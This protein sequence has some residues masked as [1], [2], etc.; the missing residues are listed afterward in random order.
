MDLKKLFKSKIVLIIISVSLIFIYYFLFPKK[1]IINIFGILFVLFIIYSIIFYGLTYVL[2]RLNNDIKIKVLKFLFVLSVVFILGI[3]IFK[4]VFC[5][6]AFFYNLILIWFIGSFIKKKKDISPVDLKEKVKNDLR[7]DYVTEHRTNLPKWLG[8]FV[9]PVFPL[10][11]VINRKWESK[12]RAEAIIHENMHINLLIY[13]GWIFYLMIIPLIITVFG[14]FVINDQRLIDFLMYL[15]LILM[16][17]L[18]EKVTFDKT[19]EYGKTLGI[20]TRQW[21]SKI[22]I[23]YFIIYSFWFLI[24]NLVFLAMKQ[25]INLIKLIF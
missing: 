19:H 3:L 25:T 22:A 8:G 16:V 20:I 6:K 2:K 23:K 15:C 1:S 7:I 21:N 9:T 18:F 14:T 10:F 13:K 11:T 4:S 24:I 5:I 17:V 12:M